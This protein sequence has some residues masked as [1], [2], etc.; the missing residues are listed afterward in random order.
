[1]RPR[2]DLWFGWLNGL[3]RQ[4][5]QVGGESGWAPRPAP[6]SLTRPDLL[7]PFMQ[8]STAEVIDLATHR[9]TRG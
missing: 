8:R 2:R 7:E 3:L 5:A 4:R 6:A 9:R 1:M